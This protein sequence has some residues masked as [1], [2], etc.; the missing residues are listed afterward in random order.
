MK[1]YDINLALEKYENIT[2]KGVKQNGRRKD[3]NR[4][5][6]LPTIPK[7]SGTAEDGADATGQVE[8]TAGTGTGS[9]APTGRTFERD[10]EPCIVQDRTIENFGSTE[11]NPKR[12][13][14]YFG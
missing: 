13:S 6:K 7:V 10:A 4:K 11:P 9:I 3:R 1:L 2:T 12:K 5:S 8:T 14:K